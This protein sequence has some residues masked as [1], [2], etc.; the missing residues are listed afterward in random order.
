LHN[1]PAEISE[2]QELPI[3][4]SMIGSNGV[5][6]PQV[7]FKPVK[8]KLSVTPQ[9]TNDG[10]IIMGVDVAREVAGA[11]TDQATQS[12][13][14]NTRA[15]KTKVIVKTNQTAV[16][17]GIY[18]NDFNDTEDRIPG[19]GSIP[20]VGWLFKSKAIK[21]DRTELL[22]FLTPRILGQLEGVTAQST[23]SPAIDSGAGDFQ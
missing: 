14:V 19:L 11:I 18:Q 9:I 4:T 1:E 10:S 15:A 13:P 21:K 8:L 17:G 7:Q 2:S 16:I 12:F 5:A 20:V 6:A 3:I 22:I 23:A